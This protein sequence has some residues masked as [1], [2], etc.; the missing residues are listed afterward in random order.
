MI[1]D[2]VQVYLYI[3]YDLLRWW[4]MKW[5]EWLQHR[6]GTSTVQ[7]HVSWFKTFASKVRY[8]TV[9]F[10]TSTEYKIKYHWED[11]TRGERINHRIKY[12]RFYNKCL[13]C[14]LL[15]IYH[16]YISRAQPAIHKY[17]FEQ[18]SDHPQSNSISYSTSTAL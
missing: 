15:L 4:M 6:Y 5:C 8:S 3:I 12:L 16:E 11:E 9:H 1:T 13:K 18:Q 14:T 2:D 10:S 17:Y 7:Q